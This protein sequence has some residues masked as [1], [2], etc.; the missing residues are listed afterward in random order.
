MVEPFTR[1]PT[2]DGYAPV[3]RGGR[4][5]VFSAALTAE[6]GGDLVF[7]EIDPGERR[8][9]RDLIVSFALARAQRI[10]ARARRRQFRAEQ[11][12]PGRAARG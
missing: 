7:L 4:V 9:R 1:R 6:R 8:A 2:P 5:Y 11:A 12:T 10:A 3:A